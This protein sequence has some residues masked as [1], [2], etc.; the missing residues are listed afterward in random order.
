MT[1]IFPRKAVGLKVQGEKKNPPKLKRHA[2][3]KK[4]LRKHM[5]SQHRNLIYTLPKKQIK[6]N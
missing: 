5:P 6:T 1:I 3:E 2:K 4:V